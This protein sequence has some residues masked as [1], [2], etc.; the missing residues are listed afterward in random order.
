VAQKKEGFRGQTKSELR[1]L[2]A[3]SLKLRLPSALMQ[4]TKRSALDCISIGRSV[5]E[6]D[7]Q[8]GTNRDGI[9]KENQH[10]SLHQMPKPTRSES[11]IV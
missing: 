1:G 6:N 3:S 8:P 5:A 7:L 11:S 10:H 2:F 4:L 9:S